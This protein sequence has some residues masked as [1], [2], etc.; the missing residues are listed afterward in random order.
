M[1]DAEK[2]YKTSITTSIEQ[3]EIIQKKLL[4]DMTGVSIS[5][6]HKKLITENEIEMWHLEGDK[7]KFDLNEATK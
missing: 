6:E 1:T 7:R 2:A 4:I 5:D 3:I